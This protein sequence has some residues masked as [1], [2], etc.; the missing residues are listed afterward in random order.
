MTLRSLI[1][2]I[3]PEVSDQLEEVTHG[4]HPPIPNACAKVTKN[5]FALLF[6]KFDETTTTS[7]LHLSAISFVMA[8]CSN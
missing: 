8:S 3:M 6:R 4:C 1:S 2:E 7:L 5:L